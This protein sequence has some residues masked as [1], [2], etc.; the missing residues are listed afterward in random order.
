MYNVSIPKISDEELA[1]RYQQIKPIVKI[2]GVKYWLRDFSF[3]ELKSISYLWNRE[4]DK[5]EKVDMSTLKEYPDWDFECLHIYGY[6]GMF[7]PSIAEVLAQIP[8]DE[9]IWAVAFEIIGTPQTS[10]DFHRN[11]N[12]FRQGFHSS[13][14]RLY[15]AQNN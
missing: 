8:E 10:D 5:R 3:D 6:P 11:R 1:K 7:K 2:N 15:I 13:I 14:V 4:K 9:A 12:A